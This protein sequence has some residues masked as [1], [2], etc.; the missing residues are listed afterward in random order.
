MLV[1]HNHRVAR[2]VRESVEH[3]KA[4][5]RAMNNQRLLI[6]FG[7]QKAAKQA[8]ARGICAGNVGISPGRKQVIHGPSK[9]TRRIRVLS[10]FSRFEAFDS[11]LSGCYSRRSLMALFRTAVRSGRW[12]PSL[13]KNG[14]KSA[15]GTR[16]P[17]SAF[18]TTA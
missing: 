16:G 2:R 12:F 4:V 1:R 18:S 5:F 7:L 9:D 13:P 11:V 8:I 15:S 6:V 17:E 3:H 10:Q 14:S